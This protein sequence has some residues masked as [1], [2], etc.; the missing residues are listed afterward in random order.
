MN[1]HSREKGLFGQG[2]EFVDPMALHMGAPPLAFGSCQLMGI[3]LEERES[4]FAFSMRLQRSLRTGALPVI[5]G[6]KRFHSPEGNTEH[7]SDQIQASGDI[8]QIINVKDQGGISD[9][10]LTI[11]S[12]W[13]STFFP[14]GVNEE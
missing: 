10:G 7:I 11:R 12:G 3:P 4:A 14:Y 8:A 9:L 13:S 1:L 2:V 6:N 5:P